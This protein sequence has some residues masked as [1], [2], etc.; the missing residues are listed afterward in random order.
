MAELPR[1][2]ELVCLTPYPLHGILVH[3]WI[4]YRYMLAIGV[5]NPTKEHSR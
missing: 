1:L 5:K 4:F 2:D 3:Y